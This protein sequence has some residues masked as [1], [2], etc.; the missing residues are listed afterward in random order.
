MIG[1]PLPGIEGDRGYLYVEA[2]KSDTKIKEW[3]CSAQL[4]GHKEIRMQSGPS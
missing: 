2:S 1:M 4:V 3:C